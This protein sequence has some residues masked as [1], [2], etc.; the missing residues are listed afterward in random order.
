MNGAPSKDPKFGWGPETGFVYQKAY[1]EF[2]CSPE[3]MNILIELF[4]QY[5][6][7]SYHATTRKGE[8]KRNTTEKSV[9]AVTWGVFMDRE[10]AQPT[11]V[12]SESFEVWK[13]EAFHCW[14]EW[15]EIYAQ[16]SPSR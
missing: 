14:H 3:K 10:I 16:E 5:P 12:S 15:S 1:L 13:D 9:N 7:L 11:I 6:T 2:F 4:E 8:T